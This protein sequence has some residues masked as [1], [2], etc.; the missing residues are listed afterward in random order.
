VVIVEP[1]A[2]QQCPMHGAHAG[3]AAHM[4]S[5][6]ASH[7]SHGAPAHHANQACTCLGACCAAPAVAIPLRAVAELPAA[8]IRILG[9]EQQAANDVAPATAP[10]YAHPFANGPPTARA[11]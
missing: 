1:A 2:L 11:A 3:H 10:R 7:G 9:T 6:F 4:Q 8:S 5:E